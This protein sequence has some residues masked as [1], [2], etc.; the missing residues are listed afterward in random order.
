MRRFRTVPL[1]VL[2]AC[3][4]LQFARGQTPAFTLTPPTGQPVSYAA[5]LALSFSV[6]VT[7]TQTANSIT[8]TWG[9]IPPTP[10]NPPDPPT[11]VVQTGNL[12]VFALGD[13]SGPAPSAAEAAIQASK[14]IGPALAALSTTATTTWASGDVSSPVF[15]AWASSKIAGKVTLIVLSVD[16]ANKGTLVE[17]IPLPTPES[18]VI[19]EVK[20][21]RGVK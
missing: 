13:Q 20:K 21:L 14:T 4:S 1:A 7:I 10:P 11:P 18:A 6:P 19:S 2:V 8:I 5:G 3:L 16:Q 12:F 17:A 15:S 9:A